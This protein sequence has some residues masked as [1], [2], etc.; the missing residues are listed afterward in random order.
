MCDPVTA[1]MVAGSAIETGGVIAGHV[2]QNKA[3]GQNRRMADEAAA[4]DLSALSVREAQERTA[5]VS[6]I[7]GI[8]RQV[9]QEK[10]TAAVMAGEAGVSGASV[11]ALLSLIETRGGEAVSDINQQFAFTKEQL[12]REAQAVG[13]N[14]RS[15]IAAVPK[16]SLLETGLKI[17]GVSLNTA[18]G[19]KGNKPIK[20]GG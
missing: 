4:N 2:A 5:S 19:L 20:G 14:R 12:G 9:Q 10:A 11:T 16:A 8:E 3:A 1:I 7:L 13:L 18:T 17:A 6:N 15:R